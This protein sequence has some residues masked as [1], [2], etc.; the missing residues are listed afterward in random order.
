MLRSIRAILATDIM[1]CIDMEIFMIIIILYTHLIRLVRVVY[2]CTLCY[3]YFNISTVT[4]KLLFV[5]IVFL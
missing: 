3:V 4:V 2:V 5:D 1:I